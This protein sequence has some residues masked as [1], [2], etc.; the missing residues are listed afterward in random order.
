MIIALGSDH[1]GYKLKEVI[2]KYLKYKGYKVIDVGTSS[3]ES[4]DYPVYI[5]RASNLVRQKKAQRAIVIC[6]TGIGSAITANKVKGI[7][8]GL[9]HNLK[10]ARFSRLH[11]DTNV[12]VMGADFVK[13]VLAKKMVSLWLKT[14][15]EGGRHKRRI[16]QIKKVEA[17]YG[18]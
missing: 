4:V 18:L 6:K 2:K 17:G 8:A 11:N 9:V 5:F 15:F 12:L 7:R 14:P 16:N 13:P 3:S 1:R 10:G